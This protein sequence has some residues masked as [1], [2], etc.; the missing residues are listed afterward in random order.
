MVFAMLSIGILGFLVWAHHMYT[1]GLDIDTRAYFTAA[2]MIIA[3]PTGIKI[4]SWIMTLAGGKMKLNPIILFIIGFIFLFTIGGL[5]GVVLSN[6]SLDV[7]FHDKSLELLSIIP[8]FLINGKRYN[9]EEL[10]QYFIGLLEGDGTITV[11]KIHK[12]KYRIRI[13]ISLKLHSKNIEMLTLF[14]NLIGGNLI[15]S[16]KYVTLTLSSKKDL[17]SVLLIIKKYPFLTSRKICQLNFALNCQSIPHNKFKIKRD[18]KYINQNLI[19]NKNTL[20][21]NDKFP[22]YFPSWLSGF[23]ETEGNFTLLRYKNGGIK[24]HQFSIRQNKDYYILDMIRKYF[25]SNNIIY[26]DK[27]SLK[28]H[29]RIYIGGYTSKL[30]IYNHFSKYPLLGEKE[31]SFTKFKI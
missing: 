4:F 10:K 2:T 29:Y 11:D 12:S 3:V 23:I 28:D 20:Y 1:I 18:E 8:P 17:E 16:N 24:K 7:A 27:N 6:A 19:I 31:I 21:Y 25:H 13:I 26:K 30:I 14:K 5:T 22:F 15:T 9:E